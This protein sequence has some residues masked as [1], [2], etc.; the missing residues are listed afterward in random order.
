MQRKEVLGRGSRRGRGKGPG[1]GRGRGQGLVRE[2]GEGPERERG[3][4]PRRIPGR[5]RGRPR[6]IPEPPKPLEPENPPLIPDHLQKW[7]E[8]FANRFSESD[9]QFMDHCNR[10]DPHPPV[11]FYKN[12]KGKLFYQ[13]QY[14]RKKS[15]FN[16]YSNEHRTKKLKTDF[17]NRDRY[18]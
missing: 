10:P 8:T 5:K 2:S 7:I 12:E 18:Y 3:Q 17:P 6:K 13:G 15:N 14:N 4:V 11:M 9:K 16:H 1:R